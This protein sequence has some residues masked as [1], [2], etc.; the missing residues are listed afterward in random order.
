[1]LKEIIQI[2][3]IKSTEHTDRLADMWNSPAQEKG[4]EP[5][6]EAHGANPPPL[7]F[8]GDKS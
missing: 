4:V 6:Q 2:Y 3:I 8:K 7:L 5:K 1:M